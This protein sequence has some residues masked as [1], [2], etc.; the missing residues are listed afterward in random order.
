VERG[1]ERERER[2]RERDGRWTVL[3]RSGRLRSGEE[4]S[5]MSGK[6]RRGSSSTCG[7]PPHNAQLLGTPPTRK[8]SPRLL[9]VAS[10]AK[11]PLL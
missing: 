1:S 7:L 6:A 3:E 10:L 2:E 4:M 8:F 5:C 11:P 9:L